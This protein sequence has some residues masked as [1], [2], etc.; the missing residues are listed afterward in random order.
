MGGEHVRRARERL[1]PG[2]AAPGRVHAEGVTELS[3][4]G[5][6]V[7]GDP[8]PATTGQP[9]EHL[10]DPG[11]ETL[12]RFGREPE[13]DPEPGWV[14]EVV[15]RGERLEPALG[16]GIEPEEGQIDETALER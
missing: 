14:G 10:L 8:E 9:L 15:Q 16:A 11:C 1:L 2:Q 12:R 5:D 13:I 3:E 6:L 7:E 4:D